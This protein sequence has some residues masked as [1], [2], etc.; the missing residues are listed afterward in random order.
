LAKINFY[1]S[2][3]SWKD[4][5]SDYKYA[6]KESW[7]EDYIWMEKLVSH[8]LAN[9]DLS[10]LYPITSHYRLITFIGES[11]DGIYTKP[12]MS[13][14]LSHENREHLKDKFRFK[15]SFT[16]DNEDGDL[17]RVYVQSVY[18][19]FEKSL[20]VFDEMFAKLKAVSN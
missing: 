11:F 12:T 20:E 19:S 15:F 6:Q 16:T 4:V 17:F 9:R 5:L 1:M 10:M 2:D 3:G 14:K 8:L 13:I 18:C 7:G